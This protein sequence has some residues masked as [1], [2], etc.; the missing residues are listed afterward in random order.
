VTP[1]P[2]STPSSS[3]NL[4][5]ASGSPR[6]RD[7]LAQIGLDDV[8]VVAPEVDETPVGDELPRQM[9]ARL[10]DTKAAVVAARY[11]GRFVLAADTVVAKG[12][13]ALGKAE[14][15][16][17]ARRCLK[18]L[19]G[20]R[21]RV[22]SA[23]T[24]VAPDGTTRHRM[25]TTVVGFK[26]LSG[27]DITTYLASEEW[28]GKAGGYAIQGRAAMFVR[29]LNGSYSGVVGLPLHET[30]SLLYGLGMRW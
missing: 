30:A 26:R 21:H 25:A 23:I 7:L 19:S 17:I 20:G 15:E 6:R 14:T 13:R 2:E 1:E 4:I 10:A 3:T 27:D 18:L 12:R 5:L 16:V 29:S 11:P 8:Q 9:A 28:S 24:V 22:Y